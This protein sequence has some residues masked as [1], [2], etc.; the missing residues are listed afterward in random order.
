MKT[1][2]SFAVTPEGLTV[3]KDGEAVLRV[4]PR[5]FPALIAKLA[6]TLA[7]KT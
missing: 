4:P 6:S 1:P 2:A 3:Y 5:D 7:A